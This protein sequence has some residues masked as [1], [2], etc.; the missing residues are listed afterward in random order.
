M[1][2][3]KGLKQVGRRRAGLLQH[4]RPAHRLYAWDRGPASLTSCWSRQAHKVGR[5]RPQAGTPYPA[6]APSHASATLPQVRR[7]VEDCMNNFHPIYHIKTLMIK[8]EL[9]KDPT[10][11]QVRPQREQVPGRGWGKAGSC[12]H[13]ALSRQQLW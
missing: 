3:F 1:G 7:I 2:D 12:V 4:A 9:A 11:A 6:Q 8:R 13:Q 5:L 10:L